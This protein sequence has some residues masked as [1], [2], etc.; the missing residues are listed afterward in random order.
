MRRFVIALAIGGV[1]GLVLG[2]YLG[3]VQF[4]VQTINSSIHSLSPAEKDRYT[5][6]VA[7]GY[8]LDG[9]VA[10]AIRRLQVLGVPDVP[11]YVRDVTERFI[12]VNG[13]GDAVD[14]RR[15]VA[16]AQALGELTPPMQAFTG[17][18]GALSAP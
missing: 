2:V 15:L 10:E 14:I 4:P 11:G 7:E 1:I 16:L 13:T 8:E 17:P 3:W 9:N 12:S 5:V 6:M 18:S